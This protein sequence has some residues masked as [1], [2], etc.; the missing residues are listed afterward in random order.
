[1]GNRVFMGLPVMDCGQAVVRRAE[2]THSGR[3]PRALEALVAYPV[4]AAV[5]AVVVSVLYLIL[6]PVDKVVRA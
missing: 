1:M 6:A 2:D 3:R 4:A 5:A